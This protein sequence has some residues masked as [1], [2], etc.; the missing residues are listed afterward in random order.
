MSRMRTQL[1]PPPACL[2]TSEGIPV[3]VYERSVYSDRLVTKSS[4]SKL[5]QIEQGQELETDFEVDTCTF[6]LE[7]HSSYFCLCKTE[8]DC[9]LSDTSLP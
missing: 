7:G 8:I 3:Q 1:Q 2:L 5:L 4:L 6:L 9:V